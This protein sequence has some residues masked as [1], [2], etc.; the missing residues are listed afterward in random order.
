MRMTPLVAKR[1][2]VVAEVLVTFVKM[3]AAGVVSPMLVPLMVPPVSVTPC[4]VSVF[5]VAP[6]AFTVVPDAVVNPNHDVDVPFVNVRFVT[7]PLVS[8]PVVTKRL[9]VV[10][11][12]DVTFPKLAF[13]RSAEDPRAR[14]ASR[15]GVRLVEML[16]DTA[17]FVVVTFVP[18]A[19]VHVRFVAF[20]VAF[21]PEANARGLHVLAAPSK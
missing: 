18:V 15:D 21:V 13:Q 20:N 16:P 4:E 14:M 2:V 8:W 5:K 7:V 1:F 11:E 6:V 9:V 17:R 3:A 19:F 12:V 10:T